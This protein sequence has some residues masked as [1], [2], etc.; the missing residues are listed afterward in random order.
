MDT[1]LTLSL[2]GIII[3]QAKKYAHKHH[4]SL[5]QMVETYLQ[6]IIK[7]RGESKNFR[8]TPLVKELSGILPQ[9][10]DVNWK[11]RYAEY[12][13]QKYSR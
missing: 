5:S 11:N 9:K 8:F 4:M 3:E 7:V 13:T 1:K 10:V 6:S 2:E 12:L